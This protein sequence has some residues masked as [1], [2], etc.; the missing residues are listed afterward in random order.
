MKKVIWM[1]SISIM[2]F[3]V[4]C[5]KDDSPEPTPPTSGEEIENPEPIDNPTVLKGSFIDGAVQGLTFKT[6]TQNGVTN[7]NGEYLYLEDEIVEFY[8]GNIFIGSAKGQAQI[9][10]ISLAV[11]LDPSADISSTY[12][13]NIAALLQTLDDDGDETN[14]ITI[15]SI[16]INAMG[17]ESFD[18]SQPI[19]TVLA[20]IV[21]NVANTTGINLKIVYPFEAANAMALSLGITYE[22]E[23][24]V[25]THLMPALRAYFS[26]WEGDHIA[27]SAVFRNEFD[28][29]GNLI[30]TDILSR[31]S[32]KKYYT[33]S[34]DGH[35]AEQLPTTGTYQ[36]FNNALSQGAYPPIN[37]NIINL[38]FLYNGQNLME[39]IEFVFNGNTRTYLFED[40]NANN[41]PL[42]IST[43]TMTYDGSIETNIF[44][45]FEYNEMGYVQR[46]T[47]VLSEERDN[48]FYQGTFLSK[49]NWIFTYDTYGNIAE[50][51]GDR[52][53]E[54]DYVYPD[55]STFESAST[56]IWIVEKSYSENKVLTGSLETG[57]ISNN[58]Q[59]EITYTD[60]L[61][62]DPNEFL[63]ERIYVSSD[64]REE[65]IT[66][67]SGLI[68]SSL[69]F[70]NGLKTGESFY[71]AD[72]SWESTY[73]EYYESGTL[74]YT[75]KWV[76]NS[77]NN[78]IDLVYTFYFEDG[79]IDAIYDL[80][81]DAEG[82][83]IQETGTYGN[84]EI[85]AVWYYGELE[86][87]TR[88]DVYF[89]GIINYYIE[90][91][92]ND[93]Y[94]ISQ[95]RTYWPDGELFGIIDITYNENGQI[96]TET[97]RFPDG[98]VYLT[99]YY[100][101]DTNG[102]LVTITGVQYGNT[103]YILYYE[104][105]VLVREEI[106]DENG[107]LIDVIDYT[108]TGSIRIPNTKI[109]TYHPNKLFNNDQREIRFIDRPNDGFLFK[110]HQSTQWDK[111]QGDPNSQWFKHKQGHFQTSKK[112][113]Q[114]RIQQ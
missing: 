1:L 13:Q 11:T 32:R 95:K 19:E 45:Q 90:Y 114:I 30:K 97:Y 42:K 48:Q 5:S 36:G 43:S 8:L 22:A 101:Y 54:D 35:N 6:A 20:D 4:S 18:F 41:Q 65:K 81:Y 2:V 57:S 104:N 80:D 34:F 102:L 24:Y 96:A 93:I 56:A 77:N 10:P 74:A 61:T 99:D 47:R 83:L 109:P 86:L 7:E 105:G 98:E 76:Y 28:T 39:S 21:L 89:D 113:Q 69:R 40:Y 68:S 111:A 27:P 67:N 53:F 14:G 94:Q 62:Y 110:P 100:A 91:S 84:G 112:V 3:A 79:T 52:L 107:E 60:N 87:L 63:S 26:R 82:N 78:L 70:Y 15:S 72:G 103:S 31:Y 38:R 29:N 85:F 37:E 44:S 59:P 9:T 17:V 64:G 58:E 46:E 55:G 106:Y 25:I 12:A 16:I 108:D 92:Y 71:N 23:N 51:S 33:L 66:F 75:Q 73:F 49:R 88:I 50:I